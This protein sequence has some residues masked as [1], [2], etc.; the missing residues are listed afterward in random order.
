MRAIGMRN[1]NYFLR[2]LVMASLIF[3]WS[4]MAYGKKPRKAKQKA[5]LSR[6]IQA[7]VQRSNK[8]QDKIR[9][10]NLQ[11]ADRLIQ[12]WNTQDPDTIHIKNTGRSTFEPIMGGGGSFM[13]EGDDHSGLDRLHS[14]FGEE[15]ID[16][17]FDKE[18]REVSSVKD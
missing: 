17:D 16:I 6:S 11:E 4:S 7:A 18:L 10:R 13:D 3:G 5:K 1:I 12:T 8:D 2:L 9:D 15:S 14:D